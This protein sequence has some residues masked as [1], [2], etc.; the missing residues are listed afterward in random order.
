ML[1]GLPGRSSSAAILSVYLWLENLVRSGKGSLYGVSLDASKCFD[2]ISVSDAVR[3][4]LS[5]DIP[6]GLLSGIASFY[7]GP[8]GFW[9]PFLVI[10][11]IGVFP[12]ALSR[13]GKTQEFSDKFKAGFRTHKM[14]TMQKPRKGHENGTSQFA[15]GLLHGP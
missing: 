15:C 6:S 11:G 1:G 4:G 10:F 8:L 9:G 14:R 2:R 12:M 3:A 13:K 5:C 7:S